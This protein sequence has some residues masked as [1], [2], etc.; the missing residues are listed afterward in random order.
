MKKIDFELGTVQKTLLFPLSGKAYDAES[1]KPILNDKKAL[2]LYHKLMPE[3]RNYFKKYIRSIGVLAFCE[4]ALIID[5]T[6][7]DFLQRHPKGKILN[8]GAGLET[9]FYRLNQPNVAW[10]DLDL[11]DSIALR[12]K[13]LPNTFKNVKY[14]AKSMFDESW[15][16]DVGD[17]KDGLLITISGVLPYF[18]EA[19]VKEFFNTY[20]PKLKGAEIIFDVIS[21]M[22]RFFVTRKIT[23][24]GMSN[25]TL[26][27]GITNPHDIEKWNEHIQFKKSYY[28]LQHSSFRN[29]KNIIRRFIS[30][31]N[32][33]FKIGQIFH[34][35][36]V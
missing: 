31:N 17:I 4:R 35:K 15:L 2:E 7:K 30:I 11:P 9:S 23:Q 12:E 32:S 13:L 1:K 26:D 36:F 21:N 16:E 14:I 5:N 18:D 10:F 33:F 34:F 22:G 8:I 28:F 24:A 27:W 3:D 29:S 19:Q 6:I 25:A 20:A